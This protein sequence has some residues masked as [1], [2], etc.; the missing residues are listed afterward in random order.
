MLNEAIVGFGISSSYT[1]LENSDAWK[2][3]LQ[4]L[5][6]R[7]RREDEEQTK[8]EKKQNAVEGKAAELDN[9]GKIGKK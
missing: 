8:P 5:R 2:E 9:L 7:H 1:Y 6:E 3:A 4:N